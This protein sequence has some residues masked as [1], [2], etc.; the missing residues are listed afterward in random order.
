MKS[1]RVENNLMRAIAIMESACEDAKRYV[2]SSDDNGVAVQN[3]FHSLSWGFANAGSS[4]SCAMNA[5]EDA[6]LAEIYRKSHEA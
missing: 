6:H 5:T 4:I 1:E 2:E 3:V